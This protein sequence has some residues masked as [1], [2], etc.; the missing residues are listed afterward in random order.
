MVTSAKKLAGME[1]SS[2]VPDADWAEYIERGVEDL[3]EKLL[4]TFGSEYFSKADT[5]SQVA[6]TEDYNLPTDFLQLISIYK[7]VDS[8]A[9]PLEKFNWAE[10]P[11][12]RNMTL[13]DHR[14]FYR[15]IGSE[16]QS[17]QHQVKFL[18]VPT[19]AHTV[20][21][22][23][24]YKPVFASGSASI[25]GINGW[26]EY[27]EL[28][29]AIKAFNKEESDPS[30]LVADLNRV[31]ARIERHKVAR[32]KARPAKIQDTRRDKWRRG[33]YGNDGL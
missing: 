28:I 14:Q 20:S 9:V 30:G 33:R 21:Y 31:A 6:S 10:E 3:W 7:T 4:Q 2:F 16:T 17:G 1:N 18:P 13:T 27:A 22:R 11:A 15:V 5:I 26:E 25:D 24:A 32:D 29:A 19:A 23:Y 8:V 12:L